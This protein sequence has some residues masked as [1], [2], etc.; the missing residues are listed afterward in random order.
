[1]KKSLIALAVLAASGGA[2]AQ[3]TVTLFGT[4]DPGVWNQKTTFGDDSTKS[5]TLLGNNG[6]GTTQVSVKGVAEISAGLNGIFL[7]E[8]DFDVASSTGTNSNT[9]A[10]KHSVGSGG[11]EVFGGL[12]G[13]F[14][15]V[16]LGSPNTP[17]LNSQASRQP[18]GTKIGGGFN[19]SLGTGHVRNNN[20]LV[21]A[22]P[23]LGGVTVSGGYAF[24]S[25]KGQT[26]AGVSTGDIVVKDNTGANTTSVLQNGTDIGSILDIGVD[27]AFGPA[28]VGFTQYNQQKVGAQTSNHTQT[29][30][31]GQFAVAGSTI[32]GG[33]VSQK[34]TAGAKATGLNLAVKVG[35]GDLSLLGNVAKLNDKSAANNDITTLAVGADYALGKRTTLYTRLVNE[36]TSN[37]TAAT[38]VKKVNSLLVATQVNF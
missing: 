11:G 37:V 2:M 21:Y 20:S 14:G 30:L 1:M 31:Y 34:N 38:G 22:T 36:K 16:K 15:S 28:K 6:R 9:T 10:G 27:A 13:G 32:Y 7:Y 12:Q 17:T 4:L 5:Q 29:N 24:K 19:S 23:D 18:M 33:Y 3:S 26:V 35:L 25:L 8:G